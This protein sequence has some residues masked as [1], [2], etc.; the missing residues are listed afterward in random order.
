MFQY[1]F[2]IALRESSGV[3]T[4]YDASLFKTYP[5]H[6]GFE[7]GR[8][9]QI[10]AHQAP[11]SEIRKLSFYTSSY[12]LWRILKRL[13][14]RTTQCFE[15]S[16]SRFTPSLLEDPRDLY[17]FG[18]WQDPRYFNQY[19]EIIRQEFSWKDPLDEKNQSF[20]NQFAAHHTVSIHVRRGDYLK[21]WRYKGI[22]GVEYYE[23]AIKLAI[24]SDGI[25]D[26]AFAVFSDDI[27][28]CVKYI[29]PLLQGRTYTLVDWN[30]GAE[31]NKDMRL[32]SACQ[33]SI[34]ANSSFSWW[35]AYLNIHPDSTVF[36]PGRWTN[37]I[38]LSKRQ[39]DDWVLVD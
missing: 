32:M 2:L 25:G 16:D 4:Y 37:A 17:Y 18:V 1:A 3:E 21:E 14:H 31:S 22:C 30:S 26:V 35:A 27:P 34:I 6:N 19:K 8:L 38:V 20:Y 23:K 7:L 36:A 29:I 5:L 9:F 15:P 24:G 11:I 12:P 33:T 39:L 28:W 10:T 13:P